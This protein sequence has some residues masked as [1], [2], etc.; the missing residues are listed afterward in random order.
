MSHKREK[1][2]WVKKTERYANAPAA[3]ARAGSLRLHEHTS[4]IQVRRTAEGFEVSY[5]VARWYLEELER[6]GGRL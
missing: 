4:H 2:Y 6:V 5:S 1:N 3:Q